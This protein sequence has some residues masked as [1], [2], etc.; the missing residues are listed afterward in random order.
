MLAL[1][2]EGMWQIAIAGRMG[3]TRAT[4]NRILWRHATTANLVPGHGGSSEDHTSSRLFFV[5]DGLTG[6]S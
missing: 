1:A 2:L 5:Q 4:V 6:S 3:L